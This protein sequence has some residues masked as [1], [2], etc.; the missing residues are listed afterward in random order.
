MELYKFEHS[1]YFWWTGA[2]FL[3]LMVIII[4]GIWK[5]RV[6][7]K[8]SSNVFSQNVKGLSRSSIRLKNVLFII[9]LLFLIIGLANLQFGTKM[10]KGVRQGSE[11][12]IAL[13]VSSSMLAQ[14]LKPNRLQHAK[15]AIKQFVSKLKNDKV[16]LIV[17]AGDAY[18]QV[19]LTQDYNVIKRLYI[20][21][22]TTSS[23]ASQGTS[24]EA[25][26]S[27]AIES[28]SEKTL[29][30][31]TLVI[32]TDGEGHDE[33]AVKLAK[34]AH[35]DGITIHTIGLGS[36]TGVPIPIGKRGGVNVF[37]KD[38]DGNTVITKLNENILK[39]ISEVGN[40]IYVRASQQNFGLPLILKRIEELDKTEF[41][42]SE[43][44][45]YEDQFQY[46]L[47]PAFMLLL[48]EISIS[49]KRFRI[50]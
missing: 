50:V 14:D 35:K 30:N 40:G 3:A 23:V 36:P 13:D 46:F 7:K 27:K 22:I 19:P 45:D 49:R 39:K 15:L 17:F 42:G 9:S 29:D 47:F 21:D 43:F 28:F 18:V 2:V 24:L 48:I 32:I 8:F 33:N 25:A 16:G 44:Q 26:I 5:R 10:K 4:H 34:K 11:I 38:R 20:D 12:I 37:K 6:F 1:E 31:K 41:E